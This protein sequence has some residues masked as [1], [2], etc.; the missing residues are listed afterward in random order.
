MPTRTLT[1]LECAKAA[2]GALKPKERAELLASLGMAPMRPSRDAVL[3][4]IRD[5]AER[6]CMVN[7]WS[8]ETMAGMRR[9]ERVSHARRDLVCRLHE[10]GYGVQEIAT[11][12]GRTHQGITFLIG[13]M[14][15]KRNRR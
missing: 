12:L 2:I 7:G 8:I 6:W 10:D 11:L 9:T 3:I 13:T 4:T 5:A 15:K 1:P 14:S